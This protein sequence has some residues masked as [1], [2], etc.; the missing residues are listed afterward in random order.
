LVLAVLAALQQQ[1]P[2]VATLF[3]GQL[4]QPAVVVVQV[5]VQALLQLVVL[6]VVMNKE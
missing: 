3:L 2:V 5:A 6:V 1:Q 4:L